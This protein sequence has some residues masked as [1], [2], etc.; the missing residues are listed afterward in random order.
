MNLLD[1]NKC[2]KYDRV[3]ES[4]FCM[5]LHAQTLILTRAPPEGAKVG[6]DALVGAIGK[7]VSL[8]TKSFALH[9]N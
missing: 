3:V 4:K 2:L 8:D 1:L 6:L 7:L 5:L 9:R